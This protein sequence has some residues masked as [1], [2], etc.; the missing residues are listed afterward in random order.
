MTRLTNDLAVQAA[1]ALDAK[2]EAAIKAAFDDGMD[3]VRSDTLQVESR[4]PFTVRVGWERYEHRLAYYGGA[5]PPDQATPA[6]MV[7]YKRPETWSAHNG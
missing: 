1:R 5:V 7:R 6:G 3:F 4:D 2:L